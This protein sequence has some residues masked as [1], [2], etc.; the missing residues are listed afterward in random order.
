M[1]IKA[2]STTELSLTFVPT[3]KPIADFYFVN[4]KHGDNDNRC[5]LKAT[6]HPLSCRHENLEPSTSYIFEY[7][8]EA[9]AKVSDIWSTMRIKT[10]LT[11]AYCELISDSR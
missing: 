8:A 3:E 2:E 9:H 4:H 5:L 10:A 6:E 7:Y 11:P 1:L